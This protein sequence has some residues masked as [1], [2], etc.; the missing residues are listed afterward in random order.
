MA[1]SAARPGG[2]RA[3]APSHPAQALPQ[4]RQDPSP[5]LAADAD[6]ASCSPGC[7]HLERGA[8]EAVGAGSLALWRRVGGGVVGKGLLVPLWCVVGVPSTSPQVNSC[9]FLHPSAVA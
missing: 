1:S 3:A 9:T 4:G 6:G 2:T 7:A 8:E 5:S